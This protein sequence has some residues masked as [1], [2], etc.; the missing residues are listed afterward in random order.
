MEVKNEVL[1]VFASAA[2]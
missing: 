1:K 2:G